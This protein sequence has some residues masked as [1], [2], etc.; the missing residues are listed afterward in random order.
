M[1]LP[2]EDRALAH[3]Q[4]VVGSKLRRGESFFFSWKQGDS[5]NDPRSSLWLSPAIPLLF[6]FSGGR[7]PRIN[8]DWL[9]LL[10][11]TANSGRGL[12]LLAEPAGQAPAQENE[13]A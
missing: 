13:E 7:P 3:L 11:E 4:I 2:F 6:K 8:T 1:E 5:P 10:E 12:I 9:R